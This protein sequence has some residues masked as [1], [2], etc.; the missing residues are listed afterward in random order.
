MAVTA[1]A[2]PQQPTSWKSGTFRDF[3]ALGCIVA[4]VVGGISY[5]ID[6]ANPT[7]AEIYEELRNSSYTGQ[8]PDSFGFKRFVDNFPEG[9]LIDDHTGNVAGDYFHGVAFFEGPGARNLISYSV[10]PDANDAVASFR[11]HQAGH[12]RAEMSSSPPWLRKSGEYLG[13][14]GVG[15]RSFCA[16]LD[17]EIECAAVV[18]N[19]TIL[20]HAGPFEKSRSETLERA[21]TL[22][23]GGLEHLEASG[24]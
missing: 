24:L 10:Y 18:E 9:R 16:D 5:S 22:L 15:A 11:E 14:G 19:V 20:A 4:I 7:T 2:H 13:S 17:V 12:L 1:R 8:L 6:R 3:L 23:R 21:K